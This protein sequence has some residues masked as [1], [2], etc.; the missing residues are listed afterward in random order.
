MGPPVTETADGVLRF[1]VTGGSVQ[2][3]FVNE[4]FVTT[5]KLR[6]ELAGSVLEIVLQHEHSTETAE[7]MKLLKNRDFIHDDARNISVFRNL[8]D[9]VVYTFIDGRLKTTRYT[10]ADSQLGKARR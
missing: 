4:K 7:S 3:S 9:G 8:R 10:F 5:K 1:N 6:P 2:I